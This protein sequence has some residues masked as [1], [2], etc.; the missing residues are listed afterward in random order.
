MNSADQL[1]PTWRKTLSRKPG[2]LPSIFYVPH[3]EGDAAALVT[4]LT[5]A[6][7]LKLTLVLPPRYFEPVPH[8]EQLAGFRL[9]HS[10]G[11]IE[12][13]LTL[14]NEPILPLLANFQQAFNG[15][16]PW[17]FNFAWID[18]VT[19]QIARYREVVGPIALPDG[20]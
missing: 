16:S 15:S 13:A 7:Q 8:R 17:N 14:E 2:G 9:L 6:P 10:S 1:W 11:Q 3:L 19:A 4:T 12:I 5:R 20:F 18:D